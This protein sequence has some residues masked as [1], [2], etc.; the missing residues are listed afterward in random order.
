MV[1]V[2]VVV[3]QVRGTVGVAVQLLGGGQRDVFTGLELCESQGSSA[4]EQ[5]STMTLSIR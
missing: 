5:Q 2:L 3:G 4:A 1:V